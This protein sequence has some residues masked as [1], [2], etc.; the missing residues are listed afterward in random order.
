[1]YNLP[2]SELL[3]IAYNFLETL[4]E[5]TPLIAKKF[6]ELSSIANRIANLIQSQGLLRTLIFGF[7]KVTWNKFE[8]MRTI[9][10]LT[11]E[12]TEELKENKSLSDKLKWHIILIYILG[13]V[14]EEE[15]IKDFVGQINTKTYEELLNDLIIKREQDPSHYTF[16]ENETSLALSVLAKI[17]R[18]LYEE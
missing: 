2:R 10:S 5:K 9:D 8:K 3:K 16:L 1:M 7:S 4:K 6:D 13:E 14:F 12:I 15:Y 11:E 18:A 17:A